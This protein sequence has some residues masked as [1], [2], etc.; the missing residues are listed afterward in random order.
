MLSL[1]KHTPDRVAHVHPEGTL[2]NQGC[3]GWT[4]RLAWGL[5]AGAAVWGAEAAARGLPLQQRRTVF[6][7]LDAWLHA[8]AHFTRSHYSLKLSR[9][10][11]CRCCRI[12]YR[13]D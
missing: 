6:G 7:Q 2:S 13:S 4:N 3:C 10:K 9:Q 8:G 5:V 11:V 1:N 12:S